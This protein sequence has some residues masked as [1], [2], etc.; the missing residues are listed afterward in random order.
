MLNVETQAAVQNFVQIIHNLKLEIIP[1][2]HTK[3][4]NLTSHLVSTIGIK[5]YLRI[6][7]SDAPQ[8]KA[9]KGLPRFFNPT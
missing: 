5:K 8:T 3:T 1:K 7:Q 9:K 4:T 2:I 6:I